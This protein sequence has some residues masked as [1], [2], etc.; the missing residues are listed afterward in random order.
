MPPA[1]WPHG[2]A[3]ND[4]VDQVIENGIRG[5]LVGPGKA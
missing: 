1:Q 4:L 2:P 3:A 5:L